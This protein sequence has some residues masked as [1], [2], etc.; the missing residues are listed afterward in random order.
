MVYEAP[1]DWMMKLAFMREHGIV[2]ATWNPDGEL[3]SATVEPLPP[4]IPTPTQQDKP[5]PDPAAIRKR[6]LMGAVPALVERP[7]E[8]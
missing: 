8:D 5:K 2:S 4:S 3:L 6:T 7:S 1:Q